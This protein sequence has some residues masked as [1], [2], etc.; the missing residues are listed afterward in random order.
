MHWIFS[1]AQEAATG[2]VF[3]VPVL[4][5]CNFVLFHNW[6]R[7]VAYL[8][9]GSYLLYVLCLVGFPNFQ[10][11]PFEMNLNY[12]PFRDMAHAQVTTV[13]NVIMFLPLGFLL[14]LLWD[15]FRSFKNT[16]TFSFLAS[17]T[18]EMSQL[19][20]YRATDI[21][22]L[23]TNT[24]GGCIGFCVAKL[25]IKRRRNTD[26]LQKQRMELAVLLG[27][28]LVIMFFFQPILS[29]VFYELFQ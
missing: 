14:P 26:A 6:K 2:I 9:F 21:D 5:I 20:T 27:C 3:L 22:D 7:T 25:F 19:F 15:D 12:I 16:L 11:H 4:M 1:M 23:I 29:T 17:L 8:F 28:C 10:Y 24:L 18:I 13:L